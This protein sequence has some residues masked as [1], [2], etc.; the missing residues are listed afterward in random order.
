MAV[1]ALAYTGII[2]LPEGAPLAPSPLEQM[3]P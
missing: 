3:I 1:S 2:R